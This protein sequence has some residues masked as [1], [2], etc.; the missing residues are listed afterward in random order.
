MTMDDFINKLIF[1]KEHF[2]RNIATHTTMA[3]NYKMFVKI[4]NTANKLDFY[5]DFDLV[6]TLLEKY[7][8]STKINYITIFLQLL[9]YD[10]LKNIN[11][12]TE[13]I[14]KY[15]VFNDTLQDTKKYNAYNNISSN[16]KKQSVLEI[17]IEDVKLVIKKLVKNNYPKEALII[18]FLMEFPC[19]LEVSNLLYIKFVDFV[20]LKKKD[21]LGDE[22]YIVIGSK[23]S[24]VSRYSYKTTEFY[25]RLDTELKAPL[26]NKILNFIKTNEIKFGESIFALTPK[27]L[28]GRLHYITAKYNNGIS[29]STNIICK[30]ATTDKIY[31]A[32]SDTEIFDK[33]EK[34]NTVIKEVGK[35][36][37]TS[38]STMETNYIIRNL[39]KQ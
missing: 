8:V 38:K 24:Y 33:I 39:K 1:V 2:K 3:N 17:T 34:V 22:N 36:R 30:I 13:I 32:V 16:A 11:D 14:D 5:Y 27:E 9:E 37:G 21:T 26:K 35:I 28:A 25:G 10:R 20:K 7:A 6:L 23:K 19:R 31:E 29:I 15:K 12:T 18:E 4:E